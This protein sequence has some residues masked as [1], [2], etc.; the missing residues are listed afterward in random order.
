MMGSE[1]SLSALNHFKLAFT[2]TPVSTL[3]LAMP[4]L[5]GEDYPSLR[6]DLNMRLISKV[7]WVMVVTE[8]LCGCGHPTVFTIPLFLNKVDRPLCADLLQLDKL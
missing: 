2:F 8:S 4:N 6:V 5:T 7:E 3:K 1:S